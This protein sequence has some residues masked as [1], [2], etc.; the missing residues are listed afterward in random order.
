MRQIF[1]VRELSEF[2]YSVVDVV[3][4]VA[5]SHDH[6]LDLFLDGRLGL[7]CPVALGRDFGNEGGYLLLGFD[8]T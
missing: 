7:L 6:V 5:S 1:C 4:W 2:G 8:R 3:E